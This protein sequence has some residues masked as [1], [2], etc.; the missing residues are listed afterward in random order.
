MFT[1]QEALG[2]IEVVDS[3]GVAE[4]DDIQEGGPG[5][6]RDRSVLVDEEDLHACL[7][8]EHQLSVRRVGQG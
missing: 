1:L 7:D 2:P 3:D 4:G 6:G 8:A 5:R